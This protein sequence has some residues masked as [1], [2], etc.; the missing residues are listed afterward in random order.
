MT[1]RP[2]GALCNKSCR[3]PRADALGY[4]PSS[5]QDEN[6]RALHT[7]VSRLAGRSAVLFSQDRMAMPS[8]RYVLSL[9]DG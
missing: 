2:S 7:P 3:S 1:F 8:A 9:L 5:F 4:F 6:R